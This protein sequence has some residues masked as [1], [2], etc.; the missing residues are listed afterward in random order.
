[1]KITS[2][3]LFH[4]G[5]WESAHENPTSGTVAENSTPGI[6]VLILQHYTL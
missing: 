5:D 4:E 1:M 6:G 3:K 2:G